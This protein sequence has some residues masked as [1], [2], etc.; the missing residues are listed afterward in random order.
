MRNYLENLSIKNKMLAIILLVS[1]LT[2][3]IGFSYITIN[4][5]G[6]YK[7]E[8]IN[9]TT[10]NARLVSEYCVAPLSF[11]DNDGTK[12][13]LKKAK[14]MQSIVTVAVFDTQYKLLTSLENL[15]TTKAHTHL[16]S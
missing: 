16:L 15:D 12:E 2:L 10:V 6:N 13:I 11:Y 1:L 3:G 5:I 9:I 14:S 7:A 8:I 4:Y